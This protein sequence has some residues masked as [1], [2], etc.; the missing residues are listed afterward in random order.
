VVHEDKVAA[1]HAHE[2]DL[3]VED[4]AF[5][6]EGEQALRVQYEHGLSS[7]GRPKVGGVETAR[8]PPGTHGKAASEEK[9]QQRGLRRRLRAYDG[10]HEDATRI[11]MGCA[12]SL[13]DFPEKAS[14]HLQWPAVEDLEGLPPT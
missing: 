12:D 4:A 1:G 5:G 13:Q 7:N 11:A 14:R 6:A 10:D 8:A 3:P 2:R 9:V